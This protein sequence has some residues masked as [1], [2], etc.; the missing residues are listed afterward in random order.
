MSR[1]TRLGVVQNDVVGRNGDCLDVLSREAMRIND[2]I[3]VP[4]MQADVSG[5][6]GNNDA[7][8]DIWP[9]ST[10]FGKKFRKNLELHIVREFKWRTPPSGLAGCSKKRPEN[11]LR[12]GQGDLQNRRH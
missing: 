1:W 11:F 4:V 9:N 7:G 6:T 3:I 5:I 12:I 10:P 8:G 2:R